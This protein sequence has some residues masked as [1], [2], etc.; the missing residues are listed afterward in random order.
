MSSSPSVGLVFDDRFLAHDTGLYL[1]NDRSPFPYPEPVPHPSSPQLVGR[2]KQ[3]MDLSGVTRRMIRIEPLIASDDDLLAVHTP[4]L[5]ERVARTS[6]SGGDCGE[7]A[8][9]GIGGDEI[10]RLAAG[11]V[12]AAVDAVMAGAV[13]TA[14]ALV[15]PPGHHAMADIAM[16]FCV[17]NNVAVAVR[18]AQRSF[19]VKRVLVVDWDVHHGNGTQDIFYGDDDILFVSIH[20]DDHFPP[21]WGKIVDTGRG[22]GEGFTVNIPLP[23]GSGNAA[24]EEAF[25]RLVLPIATQFQPDLVV[26]SAGQDA[27]VVDPLGRMCLTTAAYRMMTSRLIGIANTFAGGRLVVAQ[28]G[29]YSATYAPYCSAAIAETMTGPGDGPLP[30]VE[31]Y[32]ERAEAQPASITVSVDARAV[33]EAIIRT[34]SAFWKDLT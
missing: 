19:G 26:I 14:Y 13:T 22:Q 33:I 10:A 27:N 28:E 24:Y 15:R 8:P 32:G 34:Q 21:G 29:G 31:P 20:Q 4:A 23:A 1:Y 30:L 25:D 3:L 17:F 7:G 12:M 6:L 2:A 11:G 18:H 5:L 16:G 9:I